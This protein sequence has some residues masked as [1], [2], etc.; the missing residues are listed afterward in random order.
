MSHCPYLFRKFI[1]NYLFDY[2]SAGLVTDCS[3]RVF[4]SFAGRLQ[5]L[6]LLGCYTYIYDCDYEIYNIAHSLIIAGEPIHTALTQ[7]HCAPHLHI[8]H[9]KR[10]HLLPAMSNLLCSSTNQ[11]LFKKNFCNQSNHYENYKPS[12]VYHK[13]DT[14]CGGQR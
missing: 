10:R 4:R 2:Y 6:C 12:C 7:S 9:L 8:Y 13:I 14:F 5:S 1:I 11:Q 3:I